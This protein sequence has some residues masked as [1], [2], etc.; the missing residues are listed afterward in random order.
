MKLGKFEI[1]VISDGLFQLDGG[2]MFGIVPKVIWSKFLQVDQNN[3]ALWGTH[4]LL[5][6]VKGKKILIETG[7]G[8]KLDSKKKKIYG[9]SDDGAFSQNLKKAGFSFE[10]IDFVIPT[11]LHMD[12]AGGF[13]CFENGKLKTRFSKARYLIQKKEWEAAIHPTRLSRGSYWEEN[14]L[15]VLDHHQVEWLDGDI[16]LLQGLD[17]M[18]TGAHSQGH[19]A[20][21]IFSEGKTLFCGGDL[22]PSR[23]HVRQT[24]VC[25]YDLCPMEVSELKT[26]WLERAYQED[27]ILH[28]YHDPEMP[29]G[30][31]NKEGENFVGDL[32]K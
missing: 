22:I 26:K 7:I 13:T 4:C 29:F 14:F 10:E 28:W 20:I 32:R 12:H 19:Q 30:K 3:M 9:R 23:W 6:V 17:I 8:S 11:H 31:V 1:Y 16:E 27:W 15:P 21:K 5:V 18:L 24:F 25:A 2:T